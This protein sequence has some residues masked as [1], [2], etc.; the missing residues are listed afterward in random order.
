MAPPPDLEQLR[1][2]RNAAAVFAVVVLLVGFGVTVPRSLARYRQLRAA[3]AELVGLQQ[4]IIRF[5]NQIV[6]EQRQI[7][8]LQQEI[9]ALQKS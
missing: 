5:Q 1:R 3:E 4:D 2:Q 8:E 9:I 7:T 6:K